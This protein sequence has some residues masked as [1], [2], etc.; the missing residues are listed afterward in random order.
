MRVLDT[1][2]GTGRLLRLNLRVDRI[3]GSVWVLGIVG[4][5]LTSTWS[6]RNLYSTPDEIARY[7]SMLT[8]SRAMESVNRAFNGPGLGFEHPNPGVV[9]VNEVALW[10]SVAFSLMA[11]FLTARHTRAAEEAGQLD[12]VRSQS[13]GRHAPLGAAALLVLLLEAIAAAIVLLGLVLLGYDTTGSTALVLAFFAAGCV[14]SVLT[15]IGAQIV[16]TGRAAVGIGLAAFGSAFLL[17]AIGDVGD[18]RLSWLSPLGW[19][20]RVR[21]FA[22]E[23]WWV[24]SLSLLTVVLGSALALGLSDHRDLGSGMLPQR[25]GPRNATAFG[26]RPL[27]LLVRTHRGSTLGWT[28]A[29]GILGVAYG[30][31]ANDIEAVFADNPDLAR[32]MPTQGRSAADTYLA[33]TLAIGTLL[34]SSAVIASIM[35]IRHDETGGRLELVLAHRI[36]RPRWLGQHLLVASGVA[37]VM[38]IA[39]GVATGAGVALSGGD[40]DQVVRL[41]GASLASLPVPLALGGLTTLLVGAAPRF[42]ALSWGALTIVAVVALLGDALRLPEWFRAVSPLEHLAKVPAD[43]FDPS[44]FSAVAIVGCVL[45]V[46]GVAAF[47]HRDIPQV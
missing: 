23:R 25:R 4:L 44:S 16:S 2:H 47:R 40:T 30:G 6:V 27:G 12:L 46:L 31:V 5:V 15:A 14:F 21:P 10:G 19:V 8:T 13:I 35:R 11:I 20:H 1:F 41:T 42:T 3:R 45:A 29:V 26:E 9:L 24:L 22:G 33:Y 7:A 43:A 39:S 36:S 28:I 32:F 17:R 34:V 38:L 37:L 18:G